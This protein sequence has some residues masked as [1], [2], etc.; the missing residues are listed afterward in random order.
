MTAP[1]TLAPI[2]REKPKHKKHVVSAE[3]RQQRAEQ[4]RK[5][6][7]DPEWRAKRKVAVASAY[8]KKFENDPEFRKAMLRNIQGNEVKRVARLR[9]R[10]AEQAGDPVIIER[11]RQNIQKLFREGKLKGGMSPNVSPQGR[12][13]ILASL[14]RYNDRR[15]GYVVPFHLKAQYRFLTKKKGLTAKE[16]GVI[17]G[18]ISENG[19]PLLQ[20]KAA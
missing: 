8:K 1:I 18:L 12:A 17:L 14:K 9:L 11:L 2:K 15:R 4:M 6:W 13:N 10:K 19:K 3:I 7:A 20:K 16:A 5:N